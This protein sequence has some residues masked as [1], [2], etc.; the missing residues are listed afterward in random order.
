MKHRRASKILEMAQV[1]GVLALTHLSRRAF[2]PQQVT[3]CSMLSCLAGRRVAS[4]E[5][6]LTDRLTAYQVLH[7]DSCLHPT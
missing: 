5:R 4:K 3:Y 7:A 1:L 2:V 6:L